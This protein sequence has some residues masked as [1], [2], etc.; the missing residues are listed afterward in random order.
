MVRLN[1]LA[2]LL[3]AFL[4]VGVSAAMAAPGQAPTVTP[5]NLIFSFQLAELTVTTVDTIGE[6]GRASCRERV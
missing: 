2:V 4:F 1:K 6:I 3:V 5:G